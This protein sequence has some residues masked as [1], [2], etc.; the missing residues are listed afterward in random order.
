MALLHGYAVLLCGLMLWAGGV[1]AEL[2]IFTESARP[3]AFEEDGELRGFGVDVV[4]AL[5]ARTSRPATIQ[6]LP[7]TRAYSIAQR[8]PDVGLFAMV[9]TV[10]REKRF[11]WVGPILQGKGRFYSL[12]ARQ[13]RIDD[14]DAVAASGPLAVPKQ[15]YSYEVLSRMGL[16]NLYGVPTPDIMVSMFRHGRV[17]LIALEDILLEDMLAPAGLTPADVQPHMPF[18]E[19]AYYIAFS[20]DTDPAI[21]AEWQQQLAEMRRDGS[22]SAIFRQWLPGVEP[23]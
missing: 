14:L 4:R 6:V 13:L 1:C 3:T 12:K 21:I 17:K 10:D 2:R 11:Q 9:R 15:W 7:W 18:M 23:P 16:D 8:E 22:F 19:T 5:I 20:L